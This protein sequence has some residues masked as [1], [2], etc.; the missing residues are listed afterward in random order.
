VKAA[1]KKIRALDLFCGAGGSSWGAKSAGVDIIAAFDLW[2]L[3]GKAHKTNF[4]D[5]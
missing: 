2:P 3:A 4:P 5:A 1:A